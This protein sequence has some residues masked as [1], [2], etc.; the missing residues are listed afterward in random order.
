MPYKLLIHRMKK[1]KVVLIG[2]V[3]PPYG[4]VSV[5]IKRL[6]SLLAGNFKMNSIDEARILK[7]NIFKPFVK[8]IRVFKKNAPGGYCSYT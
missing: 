4:G 2:P 8:C 7:E 3:P 1:K 5:H 6:Q